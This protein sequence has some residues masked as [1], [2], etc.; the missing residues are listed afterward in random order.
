MEIAAQTAANTV[1]ATSAYLWLQRTSDS[2]LS[3]LES[4]PAWAR[5]ALEAAAAAASFA[6]GLL[7]LPAAGIFTIA[8]NEFIKSL[9]D[10]GE[11]KGTLASVEKKL[12]EAKGFK[13]S[14]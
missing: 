13:N 6:V 9:H 1:L 8:F 12:A 11:A 4:V 5:L 2:L 10:L 3:D 14:P 7:P